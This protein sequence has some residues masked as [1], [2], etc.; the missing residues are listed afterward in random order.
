MKELVT[1]IGKRLSSIAK[2]IIPDSS[3]TTKTNASLFLTRDFQGGLEDL[4]NSVG[5]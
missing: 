4:V 2:E 3:E 5:P 1:L